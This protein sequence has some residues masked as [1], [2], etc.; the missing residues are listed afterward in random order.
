M[1][2][3]LCLGTPGLKYRVQEVETMLAGPGGTNRIQGTGREKERN[4]GREKE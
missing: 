4:K 1:I 3:R 2:T